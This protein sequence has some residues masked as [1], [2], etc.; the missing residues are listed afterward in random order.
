M[1]LNQIIK[2][3]QSIATNHKQINS[4]GFGELWD[5]NTSG[6]IDYPLMWVIPQQSEINEGIER[7][8]FAII[9]MDV[10]KKGGIN[11]NE[12]L[13]D[14]LEIS[15]D[16]VAQLTHQNYAWLFEAN[17][18]SLEPFTERF[19]D[20][21]S[22]WTFNVGLQLEYNANRCVMPYNG[23]TDEDEGTGSCTGS[24]ITSG[25]I[26]I[27]VNGVLNQTISTSDFVNEILNIT[28]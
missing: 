20:D 9:L 1:T 3:F 4:F 21:V 5:I 15:K 13:S 27:Y 16:V 25:T 17:G 28:P 8:N 10:E 18:V 24:G 26:Y 23:T 2:R 11:R 7:L 19:T 14:T 12:I 22:G 6:S